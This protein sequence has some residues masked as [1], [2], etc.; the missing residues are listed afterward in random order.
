AD[1]FQDDTLLLLDFRAHGSSEGS[2]ISLGHHEIKDIKA[3]YDFLS[4]DPRTQ[5]LPLYALGVSMGSSSLVQATSIYALPFSGLILDSGFACLER[6][7]KR[8]FSRF[9]RLPYKYLTA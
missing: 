8:T 6:Q 2:F 1:I 4:S 3:A 5:G 9:S 7:M